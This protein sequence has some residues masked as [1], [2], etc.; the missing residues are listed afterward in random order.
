MVRSF[1]E[2]TDRVKKRI[3]YPG[4]ESRSLSL[5]WVFLFGVSMKDS[6]KIKGN[7]IKHIKEIPFK[8][9]EKE[10]EDAGIEVYKNNEWVFETEDGRLLKEGDK[11]YLVG[12]SS[13]GII[14]ISKKLKKDFELWYGWDASKWLAFSTRYKA[15]KYRDK[16]REAMR[17]EGKYLSGINYG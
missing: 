4:S 3:K 5:Y 11:V 10:L 16:R 6:K 1:I 15:K 2:L 13:G 12:C 17:S 14:M 8:Q 9:L 7:I